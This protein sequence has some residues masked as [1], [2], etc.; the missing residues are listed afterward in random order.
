MNPLEPLHGQNAPRTPY[1]DF[2]ENGPACR[3]V[4]GGCHEPNARVRQLLYRLTAEI[5]NAAV[6]EV[7]GIFPGIANQRLI[8][9]NVLPNI[10]GRR[11]SL[12]SVPWKCDSVCRL[13]HRKE[14]QSKDSDRSQTAESRKGI[15]YWFH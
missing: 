5:G 12:G 7:I 6:A 13:A 14:N 10:G 15:A 2:L 8:G 9:L 1:S 4:V 11:P 3:S